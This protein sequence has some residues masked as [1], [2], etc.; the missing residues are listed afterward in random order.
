MIKSFITAFSLI[1]YLNDV[2]AF[3][4]FKPTLKIKHGFQ[5][6][7]KLNNDNDDNVRRSL[8]LKS[9]S[10]M[11][12]TLGSNSL[13]SNAVERA[14]GSSELSCRVEGNC[15][16]KGEW[17]GAVGWNWGAKDRCDATDARCGVDGK[18]Q[19]TAPSGKPVPKP[20]DDNGNSL[21]ITNIVNIDMSIGKSE[22]GT[23][24]FGLYGEICPNST[25]Q[26]LNFFSDNIYSG[27]ILSTSK[28]MLEDGLG[29]QTTPVSFIK[30]GNLQTIYPQS[31]LDFGI[32]SQA[33]AYAKIKRLS[34]VPD[35]FVPQPRPNNKEGGIVDEN[36]ARSHDV[37]GLLS[38]PKGGLGYGG[39][40]LENDD[41][42]FASSFEITGDRVPSMDKEYRKVVG[43]LMDDSS[44]QFLQRLV[45]LPTNK[46]LKGVVP[47]QNAGPPLIK[48]SIISVSVSNVANSQ[49]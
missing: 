30:G 21:K 48:V 2:I 14:V 20:I 28:L 10:S 6:S 18:L 24:T 1:A 33:V 26:L 12:L 44:M 4:S 41:E 17:D 5:L 23:L 34:K 22:K 45:S 29:V 32:A 25:S 27:G 13:P 35:S 38:I 8:L 11:A 46:G 19:E 36:S 37:A 47:G 49:N 9:L 31:R 40:G 39:S 16:E 43:Q 7:S 15:L 3:S 42:V